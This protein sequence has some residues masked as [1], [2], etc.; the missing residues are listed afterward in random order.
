MPG[1]SINVQTN[2]TAS[3]S[4]VRLEDVPARSTSPALS[5]MNDERI[6]MASTTGRV[7]SVKRRREY[8]ELVLDSRSSLDIREGNSDEERAKGAKKQKTGA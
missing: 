5:E 1:K 8:F 2:A 6:T 7:V 4:S 3:S